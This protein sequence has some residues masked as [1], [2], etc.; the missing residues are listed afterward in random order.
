M[1]YDIIYGFRTL[2]NLSVQFDNQFN[3]AFLSRSSEDI[4]LARR[5]RNEIGILR[6]T[7]VSKVRERELLSIRACAFYNNP[8][9]SSFATMDPEHESILNVTYT[10]LHVDKWDI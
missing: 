9:L 6:E 8:R 5:Y 7:L 4:A 10:Y 1:T 3:K 2:S